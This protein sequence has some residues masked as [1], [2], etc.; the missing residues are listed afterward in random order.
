MLK[1][2]EK[3]NST[4]KIY[5]I[6]LYEKN[7]NTLAE[8]ILNNQSYDQNLKSK[9]KIPFLEKYHFGVE[10]KRTVSQILAFFFFFSLIL[11]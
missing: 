1:E 11:Q 4:D 9:E 8:W 10:F 3:K 5:A 2:K 7:C 6:F